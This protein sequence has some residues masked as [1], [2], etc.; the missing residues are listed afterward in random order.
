MSERIAEE[1]Y[2]V[3]RAM[4]TMMQYVPCLKGKAVHFCFFLNIS[5]EKRYSS[6]T[7]SDGVIKRPC[8]D[9]KC[10]IHCSNDDSDDLKAPQDLESWRSLLRAAAIRNYKTVLDIAKTVKEGEVPFDLLENPRL[11]KL[12]ELTDVLLSAMRSF[13]V[14]QIKDSMKKH[15]KRRLEQEFCSVLHFEDLLENN[16]QFVIPDNISRL[17]LARDTAQVLQ[18]HLS[19]QGISTSRNR[20][21]EI[22]KVGLYIRDA[23]I[24][25]DTKM[26][27]PPQPSE[28][29]ENA[30]NIPE[31][32]EVFLHTVLTGSVN[33]PKK[34]IQQE[35]SV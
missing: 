1:S 18:N 28:L 23:I 14:S 20:I 8:L 31:E 25:Q 34:A 22:K 3:K 4:S 33:R 24:S 9:V 7:D 35:Y 30:V 10:I 26:S 6:A 13:G 32:L 27:W 17:Q 19:Q 11:V 15:L 16:K 21:E 2:F 5:A 29:T 12:T